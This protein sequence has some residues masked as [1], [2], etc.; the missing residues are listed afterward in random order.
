MTAPADDRQVEVVRDIEKRVLLRVRYALT[1]RDT[2]LRARAPAV[3]RRTSRSLSSVLR[4]PMA[5]CASPL[6]PG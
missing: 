6:S 2:Y 5:F 1:P 3:G 4:A